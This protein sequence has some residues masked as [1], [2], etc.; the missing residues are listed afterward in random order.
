MK[1]NKLLPGLFRSFFILLGTLFLT[2]LSFL[3]TDEII[4]KTLFLGY[5]DP[6]QVFFI[7]YLLILNLV[8]IF[9]FLT[10]RI[11]LGFIISFLLIL[12]L[13]LANSTK[14]TYRSQML[15]LSDLLLIGE[16]DQMTDAG[17]KLV[18]FRFFWLALGAGLVLALLYFLSSYK[19]PAT[20]KV[21]GIFTALVLALSIFF[22]KDRSFEDY[23]NP[24]YNPWV[25]VERE[26]S[27]G[28]VFNF[29]KSYRELI[30]PKPV[31][32]DK[33][34]AGESFEAYPD[35]AMDADEKINMVFLML[36]SYN[37]FDSLGVDFEIDPYED[38][39]YL[40]NDSI[41]G[42]LFVPVFGGGT[43]QSERSF[44]TSS[45]A[46]PYHFKKRNS[47]AQYLNSQGYTTV[48]MHPN[49]WK[50]YDRL[51]F[52]ENLGFQYFYADENLF[53]DLR[54][55]GTY[56]EDKDLLPL[57]YKDFKEKSKS[58]PY[59]NFTVTIQN[60]GPYPTGKVGEDYVKYDGTYDLE[61]YNSINQYFHGIKATSKELIKFLKSFENEEPTLFIIYGDHNPSLGENNSGFA[62][63]GVDIESDSLE[64]YK[65]KYT[66]PYYIHAN[67]SLKDLWGKDFV[68]KGPN[69]STEFLLAYAFDYLD[70]QGP[71]MLRVQNKVFPGLE[72]YNDSIIQVD[73]NLSFTGSYKDQDFLNRYRFIEYFY[74]TH[75]FYD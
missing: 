48:A 5:F 31:G 3:A 62:Y 30:I 59:F 24:L 27:S 16:A 10:K 54:E 12:G 15:R 42:R 75:Y 2:L 40:R 56:M 34:F 7:N 6:I 72:A 47:L 11:D 65:N 50:F 60:H 41:S 57:I 39:E 38:M 37:D 4:S 67:K 73:D 13:G 18:F 36:E 17:Y 64:A 29:V 58:G 63:L 45:H 32:Y 46:Q 69:L 21:L 44:M 71:S 53:G 68:G 9:S 43:V 51:N 26:K 19:K 66:T 22:I 35:Q 1:E 52:N 49:T 55:P 23:Y 28:L 25:Q 33:Y 14:L 20:R 70:L 61:D 8:L 74:N